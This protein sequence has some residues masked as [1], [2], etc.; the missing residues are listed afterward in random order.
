MITKKS[1]LTLLI[2]AVAIS[3]SSQTQSVDAAVSA[4]VNST[5]S[6]TPE[7][8]AFSSETAIENG[9][10]TNPVLFVVKSNKVWKLA[11]SISGITTATNADSPTTIDN[12]LQPLNVSWGVVDGEVNGDNAVNTFTPFVNNADNTSAANVQV[13]QGLMGDGDTTGNTF[14]LQFKVTPGFL[15]DPGT[16]GITVVHTLSAL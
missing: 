3:V 15:V 2:M 10:I 13:K 7:L 4:S 1:G 14:T 8:G 11:T 6:G 12:P 5:V 16:Y 9:L